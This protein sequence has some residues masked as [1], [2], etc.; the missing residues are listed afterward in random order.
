[1]D[2]SCAHRPGQGG[3]AYIV[4]G[5]HVVARPGTLNTKT[6]ISNTSRRFR[7]QGKLTRGIASGITRGNAGSAPYAITPGM[8]SSRLLE[9]VQLFPVVFP[10]RGRQGFACRRCGHGLLLTH[11]GM[12]FRG[13][14]SFLPPVRKADEPIRWII[15]AIWSLPTAT[16][17]PAAASTGATKWARSASTWTLSKRSGSS[18]RKGDFSQ[19]AEF[20]RRD[21]GVRRHG[22]R[23][24]QKQARPRSDH[25]GTV[26]S[27]PRAL[28]R[29]RGAAGQFTR[30]RSHRVLRSLFGGDHD[31]GVQYRGAGSTGDIAV[32]AKG[33]RVAR[34]HERCMSAIGGRPGDDRYRGDH[35]RIPRR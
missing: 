15:R 19:A 1:M 31:L 28:E 29:G 7:R 10:H 12:Y 3:H 34:R 22:H 17:A 33:Q 25:G 9:V 2:D 35:R 16:W 27:F 20:L 4:D 32:K 8:T 30:S 14:I 11:S 24:V 6:R 21:V 18:Q 26:R 5:R 23:L 13:T